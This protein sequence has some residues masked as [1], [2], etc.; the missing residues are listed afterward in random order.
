MARYKSLGLAL[1]W[2]QGKEQELSYPIRLVRD[3]NVALECALRE[4][5][6]LLAVVDP[7]HWDRPVWIEYVQK[8]GAV[9]GW[10][11]FEQERG[12]AF[13]CV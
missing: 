10:I 6:A 13:F 2:L 12:Y 8:D 5:I 1:N 11:Y 7:S 3:D 9:C 4:E